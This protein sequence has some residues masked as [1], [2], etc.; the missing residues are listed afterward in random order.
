ML[1]S[2][3]M[4]V[5]NEER[6]LPYALNSI[7][8]WVDEIVIVDG[9]EDGPSTDGTKAIINQFAERHPKKIVYASGT[10]RLPD[11]RWDA[12]QQRND[13]L[14]LINSKFVMVMDA[15][16]VYDSSCRNIRSAMARHP[17]AQVIYHNF[18]EFF[19][20]TLHIRL[21]PDL[22]YPAAKAGNTA[23]ISMDLN[24]RFEYP[25]DDLLIGG[26]PHFDATAVN[27]YLYLHDTTRYHF[28]WVRPFREQV[29]RHVRNV[30][31][32]GW[33]E[34]GEQLLKRGESAVYGW[35]IRH[36]LEYREMDCCFRF[37][38]CNPTQRYFS[39]YEGYD[40]AIK[41]FEERFGEGFWSENQE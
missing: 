38:G 26:T 12:A 8:D 6:F 20:D 32:G 21:G 19:C 40:E 17:D 28:G 39:C 31:F 10:Y 22:P 23:I 29:R 41:E 34:H 30:E 36:V 1:I 35:A 15:D 9:N 4:P 18:I 25:T 3:L 16:E 37:A 5:Y 14:A 27:S 13:G 2:V 24:P 33:K 7:I 11:G